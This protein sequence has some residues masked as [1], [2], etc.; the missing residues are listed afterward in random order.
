MLRVRRRPATAV[1][2]IAVLSAV[3]STAIA[4]VAPAAAT[5]RTETVDAVAVTP[6]VAMGGNATWRLG[7]TS[8]ADAPVAA[9]RV[10][11]TLQS[12]QTLTAGSVAVPP[13]WTIE[14][15]SN[16]GTS[17]GATATASTDAIRVGT[18]PMPS[19]ATGRIADLPWP[20]T[21]LSTA[22][23]SGDGFAPIVVGNR[24]YM[25]HHHLNGNNI[26]CVDL[27]TRVMCS[28]YPKAAGVYLGQMP[29]VPV[30]VGSNL[31]F[32]VNDSKLGLLCF[33]PVTGTSCGRHDF[34]E[35]PHYIWYN[36]VDRGSQPVLHNGKIYLVADDHRIYC[37]DPEAGA[38]CTGYPKNTVLAGVAPTIPSVAP[39]GSWAGQAR[40]VGLIDVA[41][42]G[43]LLFASLATDWVGDFSKSGQ[44]VA[45][46]RKGYLHCFNL[47]TGAACS[48]WTS[49]ITV[50]P[51]GE[52]FW[53][54]PLF[55]RK[56]ASGARTGI[57]LGSRL[58]RTCAGWSKGGISTVATPEGMWG[59]NKD[60]GSSY[61]VGGLLEAEGATRTY[62]HRVWTKNE[63]YCWDWVT[64]AACSGNGFTNGLKGS[65][66]PGANGAYGYMAYGAC[67]WGASD[68][69]VLM[70]FDT[71]TG[72][73]GCSRQSSSLSV[74]PS[75]FYCDGASRTVTW[76]RAVIR[77]ANLGLDVEFRSLR[78][79]VRRTDTNAIVAGPVE[80]VGTGG[81]VDLSSVPGS[82]P[83]LRV[84]L[85]AETVGTVAWDDGAAPQ[86]ELLFD[87]DPVQA[88]WTTSVAVNCAMNP[89]AVQIVA[90]TGTGATDTASSA[91]TAHSSCVTH[92]E[93]LTVS[94]PTTV[95]MGDPADWRI[96]YRSTATTPV[97]DARIVV[98]LLARQRARTGSVTVPPD[99]EIE[100]SN[101]GGTNYS[102]SPVGTV[103]VVRVGAD[104][105][106]SKA[107]GRILS[108][109]PP[110][111]TVSTA[112]TGGDGYAPFIVGSRAYLLHHHTDG[113]NIACVDLNTKTLCPGYPKAAGLYLGQ[114]PGVPVLVGNELW[115]KVNDTDLGLQCLDLT[116]GN[117]CGRHDFVDRPQYPWYWGVDRGSQP[118]TYGGKVYL[119][120]DDHRIYCYN[121]ATDA[122]CTGYPKSTALYGVAPTIP[123]V[124]ASGAWAGTAMEVGII[125]VA[126]DGSK[127]YASL[128]TD[129]SGGHDSTGQALSA[130]RKGFLHCFD[131]ATGTACSGWTTPITVS[132]TGEDFFALP[133]FFRKNAAGQRS[134]I[135]LGSR[136]RRTCADLNRGNVTTKDTVE[137]MWGVNKDFSHAYINGA[138]LEAEGATRTY[139]HRAWYKNQ[140]HCWNWVTDAPCTGD[141]FVNGLKDNFAPGANGAYGFTTSGTCGWGA[142]DN[143]L[144][145]SFDT[146]TGALGCSRQTVSL[147][148]RPQDFYCDSGS[149]P[150][151]WDR[152]QLRDVRLARDVEFRSVR[153]TVRRTDTGAV[154][155]GPVEMIDTVGTVDLAGVSSAAG[156][157]TVEVDLEAVGTVAWDD[158]KAPKVELLFDGDPVQTCLGSEVDLACRMN[159]RT[160]QVV[161]TTTKT[162]TV[163][164]ATASVGLHPT[165]A[166]IAGG[167]V[168][169]DADDS[170]TQTAAD[171]PA[172]GLPVEISRNG[173]L[174]QQTSTD[175]NG[176]FEFEVSPPGAYRITIPFIG[177]L[178]SYGA[179]LDPDT[180]T[181]DGSATVT[182]VGGET[183][184]ANFVIKGTAQRS[185][186]PS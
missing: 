18:A 151:T 165:C 42:N 106:P 71:A 87:G 181:A 20:V 19:K 62:H 55:F 1:L 26:G 28:G 172:V 180:G 157:L 67:A 136:L 5:G 43:N 121:P 103:D 139:F 114:M 126:L 99:W 30:V 163:A 117:S 108:I 9:G 137:G 179:L 150:H 39:S 116:S 100:Y 46:D 155:A 48:G 45:T 129:W 68:N 23:T 38:G 152:V 70:A 53:A 44:A 35:R 91:V 89:R 66:A 24:V 14:Y 104:L 109:P 153:V 36:K 33:N 162:A 161:A 182:V 7:Y 160:V 119:V 127:L 47:T 15:S 125:D 49:P 74:R 176:R 105:L 173:T 56:D 63:I 8:D 167:T 84:E 2:V 21:T 143:Q 80:L 184:T 65:F 69:K 29:G 154:V 32:R 148:V 102:A 64:D 140:V 4:P 171:P 166:G 112:G 122:D 88:C 141:G 13:D 78:A 86:I 169:I 128:A 22:A 98:D 52:D 178:S 158:S 51:T 170:G 3:L 41:L 186:Q 97:A 10:V 135:C 90:T 25:L 94:G 177:R 110:I 144:L 159:P 138:L 40:D 27:A 164:S 58:S 96:G 76:D 124:A 133:V 17:F 118:V 83:E 168:R 145:V 57:C 81:S 31:W 12:N 75:D 6:T 50:T 120:A 16:G 113:N 54:F 111:T 146:A 107:S 130:S 93:E 101:D 115:Y 175:A 149:H 34:V 92:D 85:D 132:P 134:G 37:Y 147:N 77:N 174:V 61:I 72:T 131:V 183:I 59:V 142:T 79:T 11:A 123:R 60:H 185:G 73:L 95:T 82:A 156:E